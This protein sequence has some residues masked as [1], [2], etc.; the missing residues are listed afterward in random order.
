MTQTEVDFHY[1]PSLKIKNLK[2]L[3]NSCGFFLFYILVL[4]HKLTAT[5]CATMQ[6]N[7][8]VFGG[9]INDVGGKNENGNI[10]KRLPDYA[11]LQSDSLHHIMTE[12]VCQSG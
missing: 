2:D 4:P 11:F 9:K 6:M 3:K 8:A 10:D 7:L 1:L 12:S 5:A